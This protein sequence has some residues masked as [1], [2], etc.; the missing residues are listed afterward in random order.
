M[1][2]F[3]KRNLCSEVYKIKVICWNPL[4]TAWSLF[5][6]LKKV[7]TIIFHPLNHI[8]VLCQTFHM[9]HSE[10]LYQTD[11]YWILVPHLPSGL[12]LPENNNL[13]KGWAERQNKSLQ[14]SKKIILKRILFLELC[15]HSKKFDQAFLK[16]AWTTTLL[17]C[18]FRVQR[19]SFLQL[20][21]LASLLDFFTF[22][23]I[24][25]TSDCNVDISEQ[26]IYQLNNFV[27]CR[28]STTLALSWPAEIFLV[29]CVH[30]NV[31]N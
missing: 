23:L 21:I 3:E 30:H 4:Q 19:K 28:F 27:L 12:N 18:A 13:C 8:P 22:R 31:G 17:M 20:A 15:V 25:S 10:I 11:G 9:M 29:Y 6:L 7:W 1:I 2:W 26:L 14:D 24:L 5:S 16:T